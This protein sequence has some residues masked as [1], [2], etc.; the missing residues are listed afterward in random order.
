VEGT[1]LKVLAVTFL[2]SLGQQDL[3]HLYG[4]TDSIESYMLARTRALLEAG[5]DGVIASP[6][7]VAYIRQGVADLRPDA[8]IVTP[9]VREQQDA[10][11]DHA[12]SATPRAAIG[13]GA[14]YI[15]VGRPIITAGDPRR[16]VTTYLEG[17]REGLSDRGVL[18]K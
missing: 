7:E 10:S 9:G 16:A 8:L 1:P 11:N 15:V 2:T 13:G 4:V 3:Y 6:K 18:S 5:C 17:I 14:D 12:R